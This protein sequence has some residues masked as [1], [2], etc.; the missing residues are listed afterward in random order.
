MSRRFGI[1]LAIVAATTLSAACGMRTAPRPPEDTAPVIPGAASASRDQGEVVLRWPRAERSADGKRLDDLSAFVVERRR[2]GE[3]E[4]Q[5]VG[6][7][8]VLDQEKFRRRHDFSWREPQPAAASYR[9]IA[10]CADGQEGLPTMAA[11]VT[12]AAT[13]AANPRH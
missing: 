8:D 9:V 10:V 1:A 11:H 3:A 7:V 12:A 5:R 13:A 2:D 6:R 4:W